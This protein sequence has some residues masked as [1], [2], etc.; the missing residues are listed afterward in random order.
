MFLEFFGKLC[1]S[2]I[3]PSFFYPLLLIPYLVTGSYLLNRNATQQQLQIRFAAAAKKGKI[4]LERKDRKEK[5]IK[6]YCQADPFFLNKEIESLSFLQKERSTILSMIHHPALS[7]KNA[8]QSRLNFLE[9]ENHLTFLEENIRSSSKIKETDENQRYPIQM[10]ENDLQ[11]LLA[12]IEDVP[13]GRNEPKPNMP[14]L[15]IRNLKIKR[16]DTPLR[17]EVY[18][19]TMELLKREWKS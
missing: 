17:S 10:D 3:K 2:F 16:A 4:A 1:F 19:V 7:E 13:F 15:L 12:Y 5:F 14:Q 9:N 11:M 6:R 8:L 18:E